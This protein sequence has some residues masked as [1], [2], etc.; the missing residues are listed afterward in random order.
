MNQRNPMMDSI[1]FGYVDMMD[2]LI[3]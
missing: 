1:Y 3:E 2:L